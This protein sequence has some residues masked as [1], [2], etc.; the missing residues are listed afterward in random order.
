MNS[1]GN[2]Y[3]DLTVIKGIGKAREK[4]LRD[5]FKIH[6]YR[7][8]TDLSVSKIES[9]LKAEG[10]IV[11]RNAIEGWIKEANEFIP[12]VAASERIDDRPTPGDMARNLNSSGHQ[13]GWKPFATFLVYFQKRENKE[14]EIAFQTLVH[15]MEEDRET[16]WSGIEIN[17]ISAWLLRQI[18]DHVDYSND[19]APTKIEEPEE[20]AQKALSN[21][22]IKIDQVRIFQPA[23]ADT[24]AHQFET[25]QLLKGELESNRPFRLEVDFALTGESAREVSKEGIACMARCY[26]YDNNTKASALLAEAKHLNLKA[27]KLTYTIDLPEASLSSGDYRLVVMVT[28]NQTARLTPDFW[29]LKSIKVQ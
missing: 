4:W 9:Q 2:S 20:S 27:E 12:E 25:E 3:D 10:K 18:S 11:S 19:V 28:D 22:E 29:D 15:Y 13:N 21:A 6:T 8:L 5:T 1:S 14:Q 17:G 7:D 16:S 26:E 24:P 23:G